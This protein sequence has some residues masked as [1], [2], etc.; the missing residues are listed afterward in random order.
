LAFTDYS[1]ISISC[2]ISSFSNMTATARIKKYFSD[3]STHGA[4]YFAGLGGFLGWWGG[5]AKEVPE[6]IYEYGPSVLSATSRGAWQEAVYGVAGAATKAAIGS[7]LIAAAAGGVG[8][9]GG[10]FLTSRVFESIDDFMDEL[11]GK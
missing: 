11:F 5:L 4:F 7:G 1:G 6:A 2:L 3:P 10:K 9:F 8:Y